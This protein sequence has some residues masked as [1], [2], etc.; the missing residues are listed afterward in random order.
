MLVIVIGAAG[1]NRPTQ[2]NTN[3]ESPEA[4]AGAMIV[5]PHTAE[6]K[7]SLQHADAFF[8][9]KASCF[10]CH[11]SD[12]SGGSAQVSCKK[13]HLTPTPHSQNWS[14]PQSHGEQ[15]KA[16]S[17]SAQAQCL[18]CHK[19]EQ[20]KSGVTCQQCH[21]AYPHN[22]SFK[23]GNKAHKEL[24][25][26]H[27]GKCLICHSDY[28]RNM[29]DSASEGGCRSCHNDSNL[30]IIWKEQVKEGETNGGAE[31]EKRTPNS[32]K[33]KKSKFHRP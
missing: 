24:G 6:F 19:G 15:Y 7:T 5:Y 32:S 1:C 4:A 8:K 31:K 27:L 10:K 21:V 9:D 29:P 3:G 11:S 18:S 13:C 20:P 25:M 26:S 23:N 17:E 14:L 33:T 28:V 16:L 22:K 2:N 12:G 30:N